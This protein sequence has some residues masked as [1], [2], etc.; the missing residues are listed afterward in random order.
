MIGRCQSELRQF[1]HAHD[2]YTAAIKHNAKHAQVCTE[3]A[4]F[5]ASHIFVIL[6]MHLCIVIDSLLSNCLLVVN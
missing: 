2:S 6:V 5:F 4:C 3:V 1:R